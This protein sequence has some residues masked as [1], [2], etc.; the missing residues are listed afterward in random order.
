MIVKWH[1]K[2]S[3]PVTLNGGGPQGAT[4]GIIE[5]I[6]QATNN[7]ES[8]DEDMKFKYIDDLS[9]L[10]IVNLISIG[11]SSYNFKQH[12]A[13]DISCHNQFID[14]KN[15][16]SQNHLNEVNKWTQENKM[17]L[18]TK[19]CQ[20][21][22]FNYTR[23]YQFNTRL[24][25]EDEIL[26]IV[27]EVKLLG[28][29]ITDDLSWN[30]NTSYLVKKANSRMRILHKLCE[31][32]IPVKEM[33]IIYI[34]YIRSV[35]E[36]SCTVWHSS[37]TQE[38][39]TDLERIQKTSLKIILKDNYCSYESALNQSQLE[40]LSVRREKL[41]LGFAQKGLKNEHLKSLLV[42]NN[43]KTEFRQ[44]EKY[45]VMHAYTDRLKNSAIV[46]MQRLLNK[47]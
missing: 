43:L 46:Y 2:E 35:C 4:I 42:E 38:N 22:I 11:L 17:E 32:S 39:S 14:P 19:K 29:V 7:T 26:S 18:N 31:F 23:K 20:V 12:V 41:C 45:N 8:I 44:Q 21:M 10:E 33:V 6:S 16:E 1:G 15:L 36:Q 28:V 13:S 27:K 40:E 37:L 24:S 25:I 30:R 5:Y 47:I 34:A 3:S 9:F